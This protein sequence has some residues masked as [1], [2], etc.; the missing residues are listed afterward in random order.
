MSTDTLPALSA[1]R[2]FEAAA[3]HQSFTR[4]AH[5]LHMTQAAVSYQIKQLEQQLGAPL[6]RRHPRGVVL[7]ELGERIS[8]AVVGAFRAMRVA[9]GQV[10]ERDAHDLAISALPSIGAGWLVPRLGTFQLANPQLSVRLDVAIR[11]VDFDVDPFDVAL[12]SGSGSWPGA[13]ADR[14]FARE[15]V[16]LCS[17]R[18]R[19]MIRGKAPRALLDQR[20]LGPVD[21]WQRWFAAAGLRDV[22]LAGRTGVEYELDQFHIAAAVEGHGIALASADL[23]SRELE[24]GRLV[25]ASEVALVDGRG[26]WLVY[27]RARRMAPKIAA[28]RAWILGQARA[29]NRRR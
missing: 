11:V 19:A 28:F 15:L 14:L 6:F 29:Q 3:R 12:R 26:Y 10:L 22:E 24:S 1:V 9:F 5:E 25:R 23:F 27:P 18:V 2:V 8:P 4:A 13:D 21:A 7:S 20:L 16:P 17:P